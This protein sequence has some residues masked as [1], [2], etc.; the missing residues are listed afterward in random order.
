MDNARVMAELAKAGVRGSIDEYVNGPMP[1]EAIPV[2]VAV[3]PRVT[4]PLVRN[5]IARAL[6]DKRARGGAVATAL[7][8]DF[9]RF[10]RE[11]ANEDAMFAI[12]NALAYSAATDE[13]YDDV[14]ELLKREESGAARGALIQCLGKM[15][16]RRDVTETVAVSLLGAGVECVVTSALAVLRKVGTID[17]VEAISRSETSSNA[18]IRKA[19]V[20]ARTA[21]EERRSAAGRRHDAP[22]PEQKR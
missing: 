18:A 6:T 20:R 7:I 14:L 16:V 8:A 21:I 9:R 17:S 13:D 3:L 19:A 5:G 4:D 22:A 15:K 2:L 10:L 1:T 12:A 11:G